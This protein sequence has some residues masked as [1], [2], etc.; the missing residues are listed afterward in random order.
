[1]NLYKNY[2]TKYRNFWC[3]SKDST[4]VFIWETVQC[5]EFVKTEQAAALIP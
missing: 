2:R 4:V 1:M 3:K 5:E